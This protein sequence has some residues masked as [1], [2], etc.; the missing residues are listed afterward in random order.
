[1]SVGGVLT[2]QPTEPKKHEPS[3]KVAS[4]AKLSA[5]RIVHP[6]MG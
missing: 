3:L 2:V 4:A 1:M 5:E 6:P